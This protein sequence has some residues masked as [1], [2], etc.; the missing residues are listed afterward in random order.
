[1]SCKVVVLIDKLLLI[2][3][4]GINVLELKTCLHVYLSRRITLQVGL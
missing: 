4:I 2:I 1:V 3:I